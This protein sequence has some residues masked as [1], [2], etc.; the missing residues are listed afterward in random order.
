MIDMKAKPVHGLINPDPFA[1]LMGGKWTTTLPTEP[2]WYW[3]YAAIG[4]EE[5]RHVN[6]EYIDWSDGAL[7]VISFDVHEGT[8]EPLEDTDYTY[9]LGPEPEPE[10]PMI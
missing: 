1:A 9:W 3:R 5:L 8:D 10:P 4:P 2:G 6:H 7:C